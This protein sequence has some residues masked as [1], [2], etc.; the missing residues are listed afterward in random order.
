[1][2]V[3]EL[4]SPLTSEERLY[5][6]K[7]IIR[8]LVALLT[9]FLITAALAV[10][11]Y[12]LFN[13]FLTR[14]QALTQ[15]WLQEGEQAMASGHPEQAVDAFRSALE[16]GPA[17]RDTE[18]KLA[19]AL[20]AAGREQEAVSYFNTLLESEPG[21]GQIN[22]AL[23]RIAAKQ[24]NETHAIDY[25]ERALD[26]T[27]EGDGYARRRAVRL[28]L[29]RYLIDIGDYSRVRTQLLIAAGNAPDDP[30]VKLEIADLMEKAHDPSDAL[31]I[32]R[33]VAEEKP[34]R[35]EALEGAG[36]VALAM[37]KFNKAREYL[38]DTVRHADFAS[39]PEPI[40]S[41][42]RQMLADTTQLLSLYPAPDLD[43][44]ERARRILHAATVAQARLAAC[45]TQNT[46]HDSQIA[47]LSAKWQQIT[48]KLKPGDLARAPQLEQ[49]VMD[50]VYG[51]EV[52]TEK[53]C[54]T[55]TGEDLLYLKIANS[56]LA[57]GQQ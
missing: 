44:R 31:E 38:E 51:T 16:Y 42:Y 39:L 7:L 11:T 45:A 33:S 23:A 1:M 8:D 54:G 47:N 37:G 2:P 20:S 4:R 49:T 26:G 55:P 9:L 24:H 34:V 32:Y 41:Q 25:Y 43:V 12:F 5:K 17:Q 21:N 19:M 57:A 30:N 22:L 36:R 35:I 46:V 50:L 6:R 18:A 56:P 40:Q 28:E 10:L 52:E 14:R 27:W 13:S 15:T 48:E 29:A 53:A 3:F